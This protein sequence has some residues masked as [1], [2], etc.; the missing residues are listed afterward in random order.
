MELFYEVREQLEFF[1]EGDQFVMKITNLL[2]KI[3]GSTFRCSG[4]KSS[5]IVFS[6]NG[7][8]YSKKNHIIFF[9]WNIYLI[10]KHPLKLIINKMSDQTK[11]LFYSRNIQNLIA[12][13]IIK[14]TNG[15]I[16]PKNLYVINFLRGSQSK[17]SF[18]WTTWWK[19]RSC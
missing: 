4:I 7:L 13:N 6:W 11:H 5:D 19:T 9:R 8:I 17:M 10:I 14:I 12:I 18:Q 3:F 15:F 16:W 1:Y 2:M